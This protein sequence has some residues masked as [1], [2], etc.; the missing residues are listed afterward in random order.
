MIISKPSYGQLPE[1]WAIPKLCPIS[2][3]T[4]AAQSAIAWLLAPHMLMEPASFL[5]GNSG[6]KLSKHA[7]NIFPHQFKLGRQPSTIATGAYNSSGNHVPAMLGESFRGLMTS[8]WAM[9]PQLAAAPERETSHM[10][11]SGA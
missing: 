3:A 6:F 2:C 7:K 8:H 11:D 1:S 5:P 9:G 4:V 10:E